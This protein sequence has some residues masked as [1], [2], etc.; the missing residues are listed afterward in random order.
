MNTIKSLCVDKC[1][2][3]LS[4][5]FQKL[6]SF[7]GNNDKFDLDTFEESFPL[8]I[9]NIK[10]NK[11]SIFAKS[12]TEIKEAIHSNDLII[13]DSDFEYIKEDFKYE[14]TDEGFKVDSL[15][16]IK[17]V[18]QCVHHDLDSMKKIIKMMIPLFR[19]I[20]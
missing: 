2:P 9:H 14:Q 10:P 12:D 20:P 16:F 3:D 6:L 13:K 4:T 8:S 15:K 19:N 7:T 11:I 1:I 18:L 5:I 17:T